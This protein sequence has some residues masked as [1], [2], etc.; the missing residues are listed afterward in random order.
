MKDIQKILAEIEGLADK[1]LEKALMQI[2]DFVKEFEG[3]EKLKPVEKALPK[4]CKHLLYDGPYIIMECMLSIFRR[5][6][7]SK[8]AVQEIMALYK[9]EPNGTLVGMLEHLPSDQWNASIENFVAGTADQ[10]PEDVI[11][12]F[13]RRSLGKLKPESLELLYKL[14]LKRKETTE[15]SNFQSTTSM[16]LLSAIC[17]Q[18]HN[19]NYSKAI[20]L[21]EKLFPELEKPQKIDVIQQLG[22][23]SNKGIPIFRYTATDKDPELRLETVKS[24]E[25]VIDREPEALELLRQLCKDEHSEI[26]KAARK[27]LENWNA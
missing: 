12:T 27:A 3:E 6:A 14:F 17:N 11:R 19:E 2:T 25:R 4:L 7:I 20:G 24:L 9:K 1:D 10:F 13:Y 18:T 26:Q 15:E 22:Y 8:E 21:L 16:W 23:F 5:V